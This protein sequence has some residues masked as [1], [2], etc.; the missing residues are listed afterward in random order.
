MSISPINAFCEVINVKKKVTFIAY[1]K[2]PTCKV[3]VTSSRMHSY[4]SWV[5]NAGFQ[6]PPIGAVQLGH[7]QM[8]T[9]SVEPIQF[10]ADP[11]YSDAFQTVAVMSNDLLAFRTSHFRPV[12]GFRAHVTE[13]QFFFRIIEIQRDHVQQVLMVERVLRCVQR[14]VSHIIFVAK[15]CFCHAACTFVHQTSGRNKF[16]R[17]YS[18]MIPELTCIPHCT[19]T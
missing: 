3:Q 5:L 1:L 8:F 9:V 10:S 16:R 11:I 15:V 6:R 19:R 12:N 18:K 4:C 14:H 2:M 17:I 13:I 7:L